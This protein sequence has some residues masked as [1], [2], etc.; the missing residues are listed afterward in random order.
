VIIKNYLAFCLLLILSN[1][2]S[3]ANID[4]TADYK[5][6]DKY[7][8]ILIAKGNVVVKGSDFK[9]ESPYVIRYFKDEKITAMDKFTF[10]REGYR[11][12]GSNLEYYYWNKTGNADKVRI[13]FGETY[14]GGRYLTISKDKFELFDAYFTGCNEPASHYHFSGQQIALYPATGLIVAYYSTCWVWIAPIIPVPTFVYSA[15]VPK[16]KFVKKAK[17]E[18]SKTTAAAK[19]TMEEIK[20]TPP[21]PEMGANPVDG[22]FIRQ[23]FNW[24]FSPRWY[25]KLLLSYSEYNKGSA[26]ISTNYSILNELNEGEI[27]MGSNYGEGNYGSITHYLSLGPKLVSEEDEKSLIY[28]YYRPGGKYSYELE[29]K[30]SHRERINLDRN[31]APFSRVSFTP[32]TTLRSNRKPIPLLSDAFTYFWEASTA[33]VSEEVLEV[34]TVLPEGYIT[35]GP[36]TNYF[37]DITYATDLGWPG[38]FNAIIDTSASEYGDPSKHWNRSR[39]QLYLQQD[40]FDKLTLQYGHIHYINQDGFSPYLFEGYWYSPFDQF[41]GSIKIK[42][43]YSSFVI[44][45]NYDLPD[46][47]L[48][49]VRYEWILGMHCYNLIFEYILKNDID[50]YR[51]EFNFSF[52]LTPSKW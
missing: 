26:G 40:Y 3:A 42:A 44:K 28:D 49:S 5:H 20:P 37:A 11:V 14:L 43:W 38:K 23:G 33:T 21:V 52:E 12:S 36:R 47:D 45:A 46:W 19:E 22:P 17:T 48:Y 41:T 15:P 31:E 27:R 29:L 51:S 16:S 25:A 34:E 39:Q 8:D 32:M 10:E 4:I 9:I 1:S 35:S 2:C 50:A 24:Y 18:R 13:N 7:R 30:Y 6:Y